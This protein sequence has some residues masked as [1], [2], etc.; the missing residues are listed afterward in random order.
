MAEDLA[1]ADSAATAAEVASRAQAF[2][3][4]DQS[5]V[6]EVY[7]L[8]ATLRQQCPVAHSERDNGFYAV[9]KYA[10]IAH[11][12]KDATTFSTA[13]GVSIPASAERPRWIPMAMD[14]PEHTLY[15]RDLNVLFSPRR[16]KAVE[17]ETAERA[18][19]YVRT[20]ASNGRA[21][22]V[23]DLTGPFPCITFL[24]L[25]GAPSEDLDQLVEWEHTL[26]SAISD[27]A[28]RQHL[29]TNVLP[30]M[31]RYFNRLL[32]ERESDPDAPDDFLT[33]IL[34][35]KVGDRP[36]TRD[37]MLRVCGF[38]VIAGLDTVTQTL[39][40]SM[41][42]LATHPDHLRQLVE[43]PSL[44]PAAVEEL[45]RVFAIVNPGRR[46]SRQT[47]LNGVVLHEGDWVELMTSSAGR[48]EEAFAD[49][50]TVDF[51]REHNTHLSFGAGAH[52]CLG[53]H[54][55]RMELRVAL[56]AVVELMPE[57]HLD[58]GHQ[59]REHIGH[60]FGVDELHIIVGPAPWAAA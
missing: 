45:L 43:E 60:M 53:S 24:L 44:I 4:H 21:E 57:F 40:R 42:F 12:M 11:C 15:R 54:L 46:V 31:M 5:L 39:G 48:D 7:D 37:E 22:V 51:R 26:V 14:P 1:R 9:T 18:R 27:P 49:A 8:F 16:V 6:G 35:A 33:G 13:Y 56:E 50:G 23:A 30:S 52:R 47:E 58:P 59:V 41:H 2:S 10:D 29:Q 3:I 19:E 20:I 36:F 17:A 34:R 32:D 38:L 28:A 25:L 55:A